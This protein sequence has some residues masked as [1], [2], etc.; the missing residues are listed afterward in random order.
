MVFNAKGG[1]SLVA[2]L[3]DFGNH[4]RLLVN[5]TEGVEVK[6]ALP[7]LPVA[8]V[9]WKPLPDLQTA[10]TAWILAGGAHHT[11]YSQNL[12]VEQL[13]DF[14][15]IAGV[16]YVLIDENTK[17]HDFKNTLRWNDKYYR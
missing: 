4:F 8:R 13:E 7:K 16:E 1:D 10:A 6:E 12:S 14:A 3:M 15:E 17:L 9:L 2:S 11:C 5:K